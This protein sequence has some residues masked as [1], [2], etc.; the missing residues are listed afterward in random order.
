MYQQDYYAHIPEGGATGSVVWGEVQFVIKQHA[1]FVPPYFFA[2]PVSDELLPR[3]FSFALVSTVI[4]AIFGISL[5]APDLV[6]E[7]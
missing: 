6:D 2:M 7:R 4:R 5:F 1:V 3:L